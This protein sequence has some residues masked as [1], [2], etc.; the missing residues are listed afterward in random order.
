MIE[1]YQIDERTFK[2]LFEGTGQEN[3]LARYSLRDKIVAEK[4]NDY[5]EEIWVTFKD[6]ILMQI[7]KK[8]WS[9]NQV[10]FGEQPVFLEINTNDL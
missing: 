10:K 8:S 6:R 4:A 5:W 2:S 9:M 1:Y 7:L 3:T